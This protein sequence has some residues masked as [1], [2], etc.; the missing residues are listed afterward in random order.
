MFLIHVLPAA[1]V[2]LYA[3]IPLISGGFIPTHD[4]EY[5]I[6]RFWQFFRMLEFGY[7]IP[8]WAPD[9]NSGYGI[10]LFT[11]HYP[12]PNYAGALF[13]GIGLSFV[14]SFKLVMATGY[15]LGITACFLW[16]RR[17]FGGWAAGLASVVCAT[18]P[19]WFVDIYVRGS[20][21]E[22]LAIAWFFL[23][24]FAVERGGTILLSISGALLILSHNIMA[25]VLMPVLLAYL[26][27]RNR[28]L[29]WSVCVSLL[30]SAF[31]WIPA[32]A[33]RGFVT[34]LNTV[35]FRDHFPELFQ[36]L[37]PSWGTGFSVREL[38]SDEMSFQIGIVPMFVVLIGLLVKKGRDKKGVSGL[39]AFFAILFTVSV[40]LI[41]RISEPV[42]EAIPF[43]QLI[44]YPWRLLAVVIPVSAYF[45][46]FVAARV[47]RWIAVTLAAFS[48]I[49]SFG[50]MRPVTY[51]PRTD[52]YYLSRPE[53]TD[54]TSSLG[55]TFSTV[56]TS[57]KR[58]RAA[59]KIQVPAGVSLVSSE[60]IT[61]L[62]IHATVDVPDDS[63]IRINALYYPGW[64]VTD[65]GVSVPID[66]RD[67]VIDIALPTGRHVISAELKETRTRQ[68][69]DMLSLGGLFWLIGLTILKAGGLRKLVTGPGFILRRKQYIRK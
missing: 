69:A 61:P 63:S 40:L 66:Y 22:I 51:A 62:K 23:A 19:Y 43:L 29:W 59:E 35:D 41:L 4:G 10:P 11:F 7:L 38:T 64:Q 2:V 65:N 30:L 5:H 39:S 47:P 44:Q 32:L 17:L 45:A 67:G 60:V 6:I 15:V 54:G 55:N 20:V 8:R 53:F 48:V 25:L 68:A 26:Y 14:D 34:G 58:L 1:A 52:E 24:L 9:L 57:W 33:E 46:A 13:H 12:F 49:L 36:L 31:F 42:W 50:Y 28:K 16:L 3:V 56:W 18:V 21:G 37:V 27:I